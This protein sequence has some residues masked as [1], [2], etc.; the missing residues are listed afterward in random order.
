MYEEIRNNLVGLLVSVI[1]TSVSVY[2][3]SRSVW[4][5]LHLLYYVMQ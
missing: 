4:L 2:T 1:Q 3:Y 5:S